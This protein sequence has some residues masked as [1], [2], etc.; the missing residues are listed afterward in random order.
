MNKTIKVIKYVLVDIIRNKWLIFYTVFFF[1]VT[2]S[3]FRFGGDGARVLVSFMNIMLFVIPLVSMV[4]GV[5][6]LYNSREFIELLLSQPIHRKMLFGGL[7]LGLVLPLAMGFLAGVGVPFVAHSDGSHLEIL[8]LMLLSGV[9]LTLVFTALAFLIAVRTDDRAKGFGLAI[10]VWLLF[11]VIY[12]GAI[13][14]FSFALAEYP[15]EKP[16]I[17]LSLLNPIDLARILLLL[18]SDF[19]ALMGYTGAVFHKFFG[20]SLGA[21][22]TTASLLIWASAPFVWGLRVFAKKDF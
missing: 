4:F 18:Q 5:M 7:Y 1:L 14:F 15:L 3:L 17:A 13:L 6:Y 10:L 12:D 20:S 22:I 16:M 11:S 9:A 8:T 21:I 2:E 19:S